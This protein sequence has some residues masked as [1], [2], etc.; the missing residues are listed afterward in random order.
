MVAVHGQDDSRE[1]GDG[2]CSVAARFVIANCRIGTSKEKLPVTI[3]DV[4]TLNSI[5]LDINNN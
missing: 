4:T 3:F 5:I 2:R 1:A